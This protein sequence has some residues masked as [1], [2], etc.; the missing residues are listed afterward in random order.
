MNNK[1]DKLW[2]LLKQ[3]S[4]HKGL[5][6]AIGSVGIAL[7]PEHMVAIGS[8]SALAYGVYQIFRDE[9]KQIQKVK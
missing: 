4:T 7:S 2:Q 6:A 3:P 5:I 8:V 9:D 1:F